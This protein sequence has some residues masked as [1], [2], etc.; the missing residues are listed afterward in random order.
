MG[1]IIAASNFNRFGKRHDDDFTDR[2]SHQ[3]TCVLLL[4]C[5]LFVTGRQYSGH[6]IDCWVPEQFTYS[7]RS[8]THSLC[9]TKNTYYIPTY[10][11]IPKSSEKRSDRELVYYQWVPIILLTQMG[12]FFLPSIIWRT[13]QGSCGIDINQI[14]EEVNHKR[15][16]N[17]KE[18]EKVM[19][20]LVKSMVNYFSLT[21]FPTKKYCYTARSRISRYTFLL[22]GR[23]FGNKMIGSYLFV[24]VLY[25]CNAIG[26][27]YLLNAFLGKG[28]DYTFFGFGVLYDLL[29]SGDWTTSQ[30]FPRTTLCDFEIREFAHNIHRYTIQC[31]LSINLFNEKIYIFLWFWFVI[32]ASASTYSLVTWV[33]FAVF[34][35]H[36]FRY[37]KSHLSDMDM[38]DKCKDRY[39]LGNFLKGYIKQDGIFLF[40]M[41]SKNTSGII[42][43]EALAGVWQ[44][45]KKL[46][47]IKENDINDLEKDELKPLNTEPSAPSLD[48]PDGGITEICPIDGA[49][50][51]D[52]IPKCNGN[53][54]GN[55]K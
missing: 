12:L 19:G 13:L 26:Q 20:Y 2:L 40:K 51:K 39:L 42:A 49:I 45:Y 10:D 36:H 37:L 52:D 22:C 25:I 1:N 46:N 8:Y 21:R 33:A 47:A 54:N 55:I 34:E 38:Y 3:F 18:R 7:Y 30:S 43:S 14:V 27:I 23:Q 17:P 35:Q 5:T 31:V 32:V 53:A 29:Q 24:K 11:N 6:P 15:N 44:E 48:E 9:W 41:L 4:I 28:T 50:S 16:I